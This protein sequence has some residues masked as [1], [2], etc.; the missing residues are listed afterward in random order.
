MSEKRL[1]SESDIIENIVCDEREEKN[2]DEGRSTIQKK[3]EELEMLCYYAKK[4]GELIKEQN[5][6]IKEMILQNN[7]LL[8]AA[9]VG[10]GLSVVLIIL[11][12]V[13]IFFDS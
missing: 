13:G 11:G 4:N 7:K 2:Y 9:K 8:A 5:E 12:I 6:L 1:D 10:I 3:N